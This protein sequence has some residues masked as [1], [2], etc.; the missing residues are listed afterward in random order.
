MHALYPVKFLGALVCCLKN[1]RSIL[2][3]RY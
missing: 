1:A 2:I 3:F